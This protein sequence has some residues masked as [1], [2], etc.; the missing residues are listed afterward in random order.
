MRF[1]SSMYT[2]ILFILLHSEDN[3]DKYHEQ[4]TGKCFI[5]ILRSLKTSVKLK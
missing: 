2:Y 4:I 5:K 3:N 1:S